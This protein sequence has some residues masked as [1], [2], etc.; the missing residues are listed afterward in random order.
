MACYTPRMSLD[1]LIMLGGGSVAIMPFLGF[2]PSWDN[3]IFFLL[4]IF[5]LALGIVVRRGGIT[6]TGRRKEPEA[7]SEELDSGELA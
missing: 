7:A 2:P 3:V 6:W 1:A 4:G 5:I